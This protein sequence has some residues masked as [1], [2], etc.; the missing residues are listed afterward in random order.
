MAHLSDYGDAFHFSLLTH[1]ISSL[2]SLS[3]ATSI[4]FPSFRSRTTYASDTVELNPELLLKQFD[5]AE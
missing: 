4:S 5:L 1:S 3:S 2:A